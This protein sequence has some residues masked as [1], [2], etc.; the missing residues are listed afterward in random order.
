MHV[1]ACQD[2]AHSGVCRW[3]QHQLTSAALH[4]GLN[5]LRHA[6]LPPLRQLG[7]VP[8]A[9]RAFLDKY[10]LGLAL[11]P[12]FACATVGLALHSRAALP[13]PGEGLCRSIVAR[14]KASS[15]AAA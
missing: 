12:Q 1:Q 2:A 8:A 13:M 6:A 11:L 9:C 3:S 10:A 15:N 5:M 4:M 7:F 14:R